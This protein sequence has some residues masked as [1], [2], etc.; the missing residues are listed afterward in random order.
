MLVLELKWLKIVFI[1]AH[2]STK[3]KYDKEKEEFY[4]LQE[5]YKK[6]NTKKKPRKLTKK[7]ISDQL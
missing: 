5:N 2:A 3:E 4:S 7:N 6:Q 1:N